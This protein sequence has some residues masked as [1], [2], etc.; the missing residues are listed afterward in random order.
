MTSMQELITASMKTNG[1]SRGE[2]MRRMGRK[3]ISRGLRKFDI[4]LDRLEDPGD[5]FIS[6]M[7]TTLEINELDFQ[8]ALKKTIA[9]FHEK[10]RREFIPF[11]VIQ[12]SNTIT[13][14]YIAAFVYSKG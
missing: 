6:L 12:I 9:A 7:C 14:S 13:P 3:N 11:I 10:K 8:D 4:F 1:I 5:E 2:L